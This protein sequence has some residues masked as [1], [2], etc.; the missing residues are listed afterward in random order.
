MVNEIERERF[1][2]HHELR[3]SLTQKH[4]RGEKLN[5]KY[6]RNSTRAK[7]TKNPKISRAVCVAPR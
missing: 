3:A 2:P 6:P 5:G 4:R 1:R 7:T